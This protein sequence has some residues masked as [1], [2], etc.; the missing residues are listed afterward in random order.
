MD[1]RDGKRARARRRPPATGRR[2]R[3]VTGHPLPAAGQPARW[4]SAAAV[5]ELQVGPGDA[6]LEV[7][8]D[9]LPMF[10]RG[11][12]DAERIADCSVL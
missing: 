8:G 5:A 6:G 3:A 7:P 11:L 2:P 1:R 12:Y 9:R 10:R 4:P